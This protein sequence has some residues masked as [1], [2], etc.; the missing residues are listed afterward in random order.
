LVIYGGVGLGKTHLAQAIG[1]EVK[2]SNA[3]KVVLYVSSEKFITQFMDH[4]RNNAINDFIHFYQ[5]IDVLII[6]DV[7]FFGKTDKS[8]DA[9]FAIFNH[10]HQSGKQLVLTSDKPPKD[11]E[12]VQE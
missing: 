9:F 1:N 4:S 7:Q 11:L 3:N 5:L 10:L 8:Q 6:D 12:G 2:R